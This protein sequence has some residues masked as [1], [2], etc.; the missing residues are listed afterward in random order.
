MRMKNL[1]RWR[2]IKGV[3]LLNFELLNLLIIEFLNF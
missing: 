3:E 1:H 2:G